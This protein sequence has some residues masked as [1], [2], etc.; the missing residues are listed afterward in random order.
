MQPAR[1]DSSQVSHVQS[2]PAAQR[3]QTQP[4]ALATRLSEVI[5][6][7][8]PPLGNRAAPAATQTLGDAAKSLAR[9]IATLTLTRN[10]LARRVD[11]APD[12][13]AFGAS[14]QTRSEFKVLARLVE[15]RGG[16]HPE[17]TDTL[18]AARQ[19]DSFRQLPSALQ[20]RVNNAL[21]ARGV[22]QSEAP[23][24]DKMLTHVVLDTL[25][26]GSVQSKTVQDGWS[27]KTAAKVMGSA[28]GASLS[29]AEDMG[30][31]LSKGTTDIAQALVRSSAQEAGAERPSFRD[32]SRDV[33]RL[34]IGDVTEIPCGFDGHATM[35]LVQKT[36]EDSYDLYM[37]DT[38]GFIK[39]PPAY[40]DGTARTVTGFQGMSLADVS[41]RR[42][43]NKLF[44]PLGKSTDQTMHRAFHAWGGGASRI[45]VP[46]AHSP[47]VQDFGTCTCTCRFGALEFLIKNQ[48]NGM[49]LAEKSTEFKAL[50]AMMREHAVQNVGSSDIADPVLANLATSTIER[51]QRHIALYQAAVSPE[52]TGQ[53]LQAWGA[54]IPENLEA[55]SPQERADTLRQE[56]RA[57]A[58]SI[59]AEGGQVPEGEAFGPIAGMVNAYQRE[60]ELTM[61]QIDGFPAPQDA[62]QTLSFLAPLANQLAKMVDRNPEGAGAVI[63]R[64]AERFD[65]QSVTRLLFVLRDKPALGD[66]ALQHLA[67][68]DPEKLMKIA[69]RAAQKSISATDPNSAKLNT[70]R[71]F[72]LLPKIDVI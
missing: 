2:Q 12:K 8:H 24:V 17:F 13:Q 46:Q 44:T 63:A 45:D 58:R 10:R 35:V 70:L 42:A 53:L 28:L 64:F 43:F 34:N 41:N 61:M 18:R 39:D 32:F 65:E 66:R 56:A 21:E 5:A 52:R 1:I 25:R 71:V 54:Q 16:D 68:R 67:E 20:E 22:S 69:A 59:T 7:S 55:M 27:T 6:A 51:T 19:T 38:G 31:P 3:P 72:D 37:V 60:V 26:F 9:D 40:E 57:C 29:R 14:L 30:L 49:S 62:K 50:Q 23:G 11:Q 36:G 47:A 48:D 33:A 15:E 4:D